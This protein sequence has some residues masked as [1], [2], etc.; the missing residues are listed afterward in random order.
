MTQAIQHASTAVAAN[1]DEQSASEIFEALVLNN[2]LSKMTKE[3]RIQYYKLVCERVGLDPYQKPFDLINLSGKLTLYANKTCTAQLTQKRNLRVSIV[4][5]EQIGDQ[6]VVTAK[7]ETPNGGCSEDIGAV[8]I[9]GLQGDAAS[10]AIMKA[11]TKAKRR[12]ILAACGLGLLDE[13]EIH[14]IPQAEPVAI[15]IK[16]EPTI[17]EME[18]VAIWQDTLTAVTSCEELTAVVIEL[19][20]ANKNVQDAVRS[21]LRAAQERLNCSWRKDVGYVNQGAV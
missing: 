6:Y 5:R 16:P 11:T 7:C 15:E 14:T 9:R 2:D 10:N 18:S 4:A 8:T 3:Q 21:D 12:A 1:V 19:K 17:A 20:S 13:E